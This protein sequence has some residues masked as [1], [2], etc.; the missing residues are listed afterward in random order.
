MPATIEKDEVG[1]PMGENL[2]IVTT[3]IKCTITP[4]YKGGNPT[5]DGEI[6][7]VLPYTEATV[8][9]S[10]TKPKERLFSICNQLNK[11][12]IF[13]KIAD[14]MVRFSIDTKRATT[15][16]PANAPKELHIIITGEGPKKNSIA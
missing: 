16:D 6:T 4:I 8:E 1:F 2:S 12:E 3:G 14:C 10:T 13:N 9:T 15:A 5:E 11:K 7:I